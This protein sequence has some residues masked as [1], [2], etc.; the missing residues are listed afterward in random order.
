MDFDP[1]RMAATV[2]MAGE[3]RVFFERLLDNF[4][5]RVHGRN[6]T[7]KSKLVLVEQQIAMQRCASN[8][9]TGSGKASQK[10]SIYSL[11]GK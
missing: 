2:L 10:P 3:I 8:D 9:T 4:L 6:R 1:W 11:L 5:T 7:R